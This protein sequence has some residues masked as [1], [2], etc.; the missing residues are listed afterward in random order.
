MGLVSGMSPFTQ[1]HG[2]IRRFIAYIRRILT[3]KE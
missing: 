1:S 3:R 2:P